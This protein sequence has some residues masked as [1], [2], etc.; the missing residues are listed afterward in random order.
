MNNRDPSS[1]VSLAHGNHGQNM[2]VFQCSIIYSRNVP[3]RLL[4]SV[5]LLSFPDPLTHNSINHFYLF[6]KIETGSLYLYNCMDLTV[7]SRHGY[8]NWLSSNLSPVCWDGKGV[9][10]MHH[11]YPFLMMKGLLSL[12]QSWVTFYFPDTNIWWSLSGLTPFSLCFP[13]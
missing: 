13:R 11:G 1:R 2:F 7:E 6:L 10:H 3:L 5:S 8:N 9:K 4:Q 12:R